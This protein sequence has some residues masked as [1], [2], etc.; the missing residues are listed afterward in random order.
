MTE[1]AVVR[2]PTQALMHDGAR[3]RPFPSP[4]SPREAQTAASQGR[5][6]G[7]LAGTSEELGLFSKGMVQHL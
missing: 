7:P 5:D 3:I 6:A 2:L 1:Q 4:W